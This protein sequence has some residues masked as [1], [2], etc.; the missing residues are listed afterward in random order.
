MR[1]SRTAA[2]EVGEVYCIENRAS[3]ICIIECL[4]LQQV[5][6]F[7]AILEMRMKFAT[8]NLL[9][10][11]TF[12]NLTIKE[13]A[14]VDFQGNII[15]V[16]KSQFLSCST[17]IDLYFVVVNKLTLRHSKQGR[18][19]LKRILNS[20][21]EVNSLVPC[22]KL[23]AHYWPQTTTH[24]DLFTRIQLLHVRQITDRALV[25]FSNPTVQNCNYYYYIIIV[26]F[27]S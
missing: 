12:K 9:Q 20:F 10:T 13:R 15:I 3:S 6:S 8:I 26:Q 19:Q 18:K 23:H 25:V 14:K 16:C 2:L 21:T 11:E 4:S 5:D 17:C 24:P 27:E 7:F 22:F 1:L